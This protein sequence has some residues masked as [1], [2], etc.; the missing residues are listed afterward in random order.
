M[1]PSSSYSSF[2]W[3]TFVVVAALQLI[4][5][6]GSD[7]FKID[8]S[9]LELDESNFDSAISSLDYVFVDFYA[10]WCGH[11]KRLSPELDAAA[12]ILAGLERPIAVAKVNADKYRNLASKF[13]VDGFPTLKLFIHGVPMDYNGP[14]QSELLV[15]ILKKFVA[16]DI[17]ILQSDDDISNF[18]EAA[19]TYFPIF[20]GFGLN[21]SLIE[22][23]SMKYKKKA[24]FAIAKNFSEDVMVKYDFDKVPALVSLHPK[25]NEMGVFY[26]PFEDKFLEDY[27]KQSL[28]PLCL[29]LNF[30]T[31]KLL[32][33]DD[34]KIVL[35]I[36]KDD[37][38]DN[39]VKLIK[40]LRAA[41]SANRDLIFAYVGWEQWEGFVEAFDVNRWT[42]LPRMVVWD[43]KEEYY[44]VEGSE[45][46]V[47][48]DHGSQISRFLEGYREGRIVKKTFAGPSFI[49]YINSLISINTVYLIVFI[50][51]IVM[52][53]RSIGGFD[54][55]EAPSSRQAGSSSE[56]TTGLVK[57]TKPDKE[58]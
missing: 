40:M 46:L 44:S 48:E 18:V 17:S 35:T 19:G 2:M 52:L 54:K 10:P 16:P 20:V 8:G 38:E 32:K 28:L 7:Q 57:E 30:D 47:D 36:M 14:R 56:A 55:D 33:D 34:R 5:L 49:G 26:G 9:V 4:A 11:C 24:W 27:I 22:G 31:I 43:G 45:S 23:F 13:D 3:V 41:A 15:R 51:V 39:S 58:D 12:P 42:S 37:S 1:G 6:R 29:P 25:Y 50:V 53:I 21:E